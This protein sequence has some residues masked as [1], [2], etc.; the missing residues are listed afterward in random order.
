M[1]QPVGY[2]GSTRWVPERIQTSVKYPISYPIGYPGSVVPGYSSL[3]NTIILTR[4]HIGFICCQSCSHMT[5]MLFTDVINAS[6][7]IANFIVCCLT[8]Y[9]HRCPGKQKLMTLSR[10]LYGDE[11]YIIVKDGVW[12]VVRKIRY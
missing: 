4:I 6:I 2:P 1:Y 9:A 7:I 8:C 3:K 11:D 5:M 12:H 10:G